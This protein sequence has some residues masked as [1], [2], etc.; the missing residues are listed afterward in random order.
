MQV[1]IHDYRMDG[2]DYVV[3]FRTIT[4]SGK[5][6]ITEHMI[7]SEQAKNKSQKEIIELAWIAVKDTVEIHAERVEREMETDPVQCDLIGQK[8]I[9]PKSKPARL[10][11][12]GPWFIEQSETVQTIT[13]SAILYDQY[14]KEI[15]ANALKWRLANAPDHVSF[16]ENVLTIQPV[17]L[18]EKVT[19]HL[20]ASTDGVEEKISVSLLTYQPKT[21]EERVL[22]LEDQTEKLKKENLTTM[23]AVTEAFEQG[24]TTE[25]KTKTNM[26]AITDLYEQTQELQSADGK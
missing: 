8:L 2:S 4:S 25:E 10:D 20:L 6:F 7:S 23:R 19:F 26:I 17:T 22:M 13:Y 16:N 14:G 11:L 12:V 15:A 1:Y 18:E 21:V 24:V 3:S 5:E 9:E